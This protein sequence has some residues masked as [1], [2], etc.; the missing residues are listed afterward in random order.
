MASHSAISLGGPDLRRPASARVQQRKTLPGQPGGSQKTVD[1][2]C[3]ARPL[4]QV[5]LDLAQ[6][7]AKR[8]QHAQVVF[9]DMISTR[10]SELIVNPSTQLAT[11]SAALADPSRRPAEPG[12]CCA[13]RQAL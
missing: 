5:E 2:F 1:R 6:V 8:A 12:C 3:V 7:D 4:R 10:L 9:Q 13:F 11:F